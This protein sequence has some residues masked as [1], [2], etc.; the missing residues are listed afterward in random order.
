[1]FSIKCLRTFIKKFNNIELK[2]LV[3]TNWVHGYFNLTL[4]ADNRSEYY[5]RKI[6]PK[7]HTHILK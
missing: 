7:T 4:K 1:M 5:I 6:R 3:H 2:R